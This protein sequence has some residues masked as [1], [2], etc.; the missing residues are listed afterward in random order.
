[1]SED[2]EADT[3]CCASC[4]IAKV[5]DIKLKECAD[6]KSVKYCSDECQTNHK[7]QHEEDCKKRVVELRDELLFKQPESSHIG[8]CPICCLPLSLDLSKSTMTTCCSKIICKG[9]NHANKIREAE[10]RLEH[11]CLFC[12]KPTVETDEECD[13]NRMKRI[14]ANDQA[15]MCAEG[16]QQSKK[17]DYIRAFQYFTKAA[18][19]GDVEVH[20]RLA[21]MY[22]HGE[23]VE[24]DRGKVIHHME[25]A[26]IG[27]H[28]NARFNLGCIEWNNGNKERA[29]KHW[30][31]A[32]AQGD[33]DSIKALM[34]AYKGG[35]VSKENLAAAL[36]GQKAAV[37]ETKSP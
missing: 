28:P 32:A 25:E 24:K 9:C 35:F 22:E 7:S 15:A 2:N 26:A 34:V 8:D 10:K 21:G 5:D 16:V 3:S 36:R 23:G 6:C 33:D 13:R 11:S 14:E 20:Y 37:D 30:I 31:I 4:R 19:L 18:E 12:R 1:M 29:V 27:G 17:G